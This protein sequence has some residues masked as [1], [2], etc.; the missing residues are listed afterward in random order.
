VRVA[1][2]ARLAEGFVGEEAAWL[3][4]VAGGSVRVF[5]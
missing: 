1:A 3:A 5:A 2:A 4:Q